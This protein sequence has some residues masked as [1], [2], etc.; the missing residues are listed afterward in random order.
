MV[1][2]FVNQKGGVGK[3]TLA[4]NLVA[5]CASKGLNSL[6]VDLDPQG[7][8]SKLL[9]DSK[10]ESKTS[11]R[12]F[13]GHDPRTLVEG[14]LLKGVNIIKSTLD[15]EKEMTTRNISTLKSSI[16][17][18]S[19]EYD[20]IVIDTRPSVDTAFTS[21]IKVADIAIVPVVPE[22]SSLYDLPNMVRLIKSSSTNAQ[23]KFVINNIDKRIKSHSI[24]TTRMENKIPIQY[25]LIHSSA[26][27]KNA[28]MKRQDV[29]SYDPNSRASKELGMLFQ[30][31]LKEVQR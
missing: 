19:G 2:S 7:T 6:I 11:A 3:S 29:F 9:T 20:I 31:L 8:V 17:M 28:M 16:D 15:L 5:Y 10:D 23:M 25:P 4:F 1:I 30:R 26:T 13:K 18:L 21:A 27:V 22:V 14:T 24:I 12:I